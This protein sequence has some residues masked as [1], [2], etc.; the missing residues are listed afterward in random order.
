MQ[1]VLNSFLLQTGGTDSQT[2][3][4]ENPLSMRDGESQGLFSDLISIH[5]TESLFQQD[6]FTEFYEGLLS[7][8]DGLEHFV[9][10][11][12]PEA[13]SEQADKVLDLLDES[14]FD[15]NRF[16]RELQATH[17]LLIR[18]DGEG[19]KELSKELLQYFE[20][21]R[22]QIAS[23]M[24]RN[25]EFFLHQINEQKSTGAELRPKLNLQPSS[26][27]Q[28]HA[29]ASPQ[30]RSAVHSIQTALSNAKLENAP[31]ELGAVRE[32]LL[33]LVSQEPASIVQS[34]ATSAASA[35]KAAASQS[36]MVF[37]AT[38]SPS[39][40]QTLTA[41]ADRLGAILGDKLN[42][43]L[44]STR[45]ESTATIRLDPPD[46]GR[47]DVK[48]KSDGDRL[49]VQLSSSV[50]PTRDALQ[51]TLER[52]RLDLGLSFSEVDVSLADSSDPKA[53]RD[54]EVITN[55]ETIQTNMEEEQ[56]LN[57]VDEVLARV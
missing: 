17:A 18:S 30:E 23:S 44:S 5:T 49:V 42:I 32:P 57:Q 16:E 38:V 35:T 37:V 31:I 40:R 43:Q 28:Q 56:Q 51:Q 27:A 21:E 53:F 2:G 45:T 9:Q 11:E 50:A 54:E 39:D 20:R 52:L 46:L 29:V 12:V 26:A 25:I 55:F 47:L 3:V 10:G 24:N 34:V 6:V 1:S 8:K 19:V 13:L 14:P 36:P 22:P 7:L 33:K 4:S 15:L 48:L 41:L